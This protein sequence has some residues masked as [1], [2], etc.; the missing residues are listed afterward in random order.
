[1]LCGKIACEGKVF[2][3]I[4]KI[5]WRHSLQAKTGKRVVCGTL[6][7]DDIINERWMDGDLYYFIGVGRERDGSEYD[8]LG[9]G[10]GPGA[11]VGREIW[12]GKLGSVFQEPSELGG[13]LLGGTRHTPFHRSWRYRRWYT[14]HA[15]RTTRGLC[16][17]KLVLS[18][19]PTQGILHEWLGLP[20]R[21]SWGECH[22]WQSSSKEG[23][24]LDHEGDARTTGRE[25]ETSPLFFELRAFCWSIHTSFS[26]LIINYRC[27]LIWR[28]G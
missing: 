23:Y 1:M 7:L 9:L 20:L 2:D 10:L 14:L 17:S 21:A 16:S 28:G 3:I 8:S 24:P 4:S 19:I 5:K 12:R 22:Q 18:G 27:C 11:F 6:G 26:H 15:F 25:V 13:D